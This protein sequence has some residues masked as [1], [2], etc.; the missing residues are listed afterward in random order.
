M[1]ILDIGKATAFFAV[2]FTKIRPFIHNQNL[3]VAL[4]VCYKNM[5]ILFNTIQAIILRKI[6]RLYVISVRNYKSLGG[7]NFSLFFHITYPI[8]T[9]S[10][11]GEGQKYNWHN[12]TNGDV[13]ALS[14]V[15]SAPACAQGSNVRMMHLTQG[16]WVHCSTDNNK[17]KLSC[18]KE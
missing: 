17:I 10:E 13:V 2:F 4:T 12:S 11:G 3:W 7:V 14:T 16:G 8:I 18:I 5:Y 9:R 1:F 6:P 15:V